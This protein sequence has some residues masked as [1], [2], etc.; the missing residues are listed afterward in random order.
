[1]IARYMAGVVAGT[2][3][4]P[5]ASLLR[6]VL[7]VPAL[8]YSGGLKLYLLLYRAGVRKQARLSKPVISVGN[9]T[10]GGTGKT[11]LVAMICSSLA[12]R[13][14]RAAVLSRGYR[15]MFEHSAAVVAT[16]DRLELTPR[17]AGDEAYLLAHLLPETPVLV[18]KDRRRTGTMAIERFQPD[19]LI[20]DDGMQFYQLYR[21]LDIATV[22]ALDPFHNGWTLPRGLL[23]E[24]PSHIRR[25]QVIVVTNSDRVA[26]SGLTRLL[27]H[28]ARL[29]PAS[30]VFTATTVAHALHPLD[31]SAAIP[32]EWLQ[33]KRVATL[34][35]LAY[36]QAFEEQMRALGAEVV[37][38]ARLPDHEEPTMAQL[39]EFV[40]QAATRGAEAVIVSQKD[41]VKLPP[42]NRPLPFYALGSTLA[43]DD[44]DRFLKRI[45]AVVRQSSGGAGG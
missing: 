44:T 13:G 8:A 7:S 3:L 17:Q 30:E 26:P 29:A 40:A 24:P 27:Q 37:H 25:A 12:N 20:L 18:G 10:S 19:V 5:G 9:I 2:R 4:G 11:P 45:M 32:V 33:G 34:C 1:M 43:V 35:A 31:R 28:L 14:I 21:D 42:I 6:G 36:P 38:A 15:G 41:A 22:N 39:Q 23:R 16:P